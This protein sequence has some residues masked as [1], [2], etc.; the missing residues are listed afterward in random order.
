MVP[1]DIGDRK[2]WDHVNRRYGFG[3]PSKC[4][5]TPLEK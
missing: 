5:E 3:F 2:K 4:N 1:D